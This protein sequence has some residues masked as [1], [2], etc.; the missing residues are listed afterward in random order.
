MS[1]VHIQL[2][3]AGHFHSPSQPFKDIE[4]YSLKSRR[5]W[6]GS[7]LL[8][9]PTIPSSGFLPGGALPDA[10]VCISECPFGPLDL[11]LSS[12]HSVSPHLVQS[13]T[14]PLEVS[15]FVSFSGVSIYKQNKVRGKSM[16]F[17]VYPCP[18]VH[19]ELQIKESIASA[20]RIYSL[21]SHCFIS[22][23]ILINF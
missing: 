15:G 6:K 21:K 18:E 16:L 8:S 7:L 14:M 19:T 4:H 17:L 13:H 20:M 12:A 2:Q 1:R 23:R 11:L 22:Q 3:W 10:H 5:N 9:I